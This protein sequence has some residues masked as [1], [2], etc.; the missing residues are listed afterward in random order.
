MLAGVALA[1]SGEFSFLFA[2]LGVELGVV[3]DE[4]FS[5]M[6]AS[7]GVSIAHLAIR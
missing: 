5:L 1:Q 7:A 4:M 3:G 2:R 6:L